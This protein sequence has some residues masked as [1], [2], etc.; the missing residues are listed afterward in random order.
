MLHS[1]MMEEIRIWIGRLA[2]QS[3]D[4]IYYVGTVA[5]AS[6]DGVADA[7]NVKT[8]EIMTLR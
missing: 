5:F 1:T 4:G 7:I 3:A 2:D 8:A 6:K